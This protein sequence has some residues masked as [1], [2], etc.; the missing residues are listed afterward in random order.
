MGRLEPIARLMTTD[1]GLKEMMIV[2]LRVVIA[3]V[4]SAPLILS[5]RAT[6]PV[7]AIGV[8]ITIL[9]IGIAVPI[10]SVRVTDLPVLPGLRRYV[11]MLLQPGRHSRMTAQVIRVVGHIA[12]DSGMVRQK[13]L[14]L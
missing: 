5:V 11:R 4:C 10:L 13:A 6:K 1:Y 12:A 3:G 2:A 14:P 9:P 7:L 8:T